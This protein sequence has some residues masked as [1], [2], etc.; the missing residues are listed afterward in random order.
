MC[1]GG[2]Y[3]IFMAREGSVLLQHCWYLPM[4]KTTN[5][6]KWKVASILFSQQ[7][8]SSDSESGVSDRCIVN[9][10]YNLPTAVNSPVTYFLSRKVP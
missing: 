3:Y 4:Q 9:S 7:L 6:S 10:Y 1:F 8:L 2:L 5:V